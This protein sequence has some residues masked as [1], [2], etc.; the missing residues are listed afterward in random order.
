MDASLSP[1]SERP[2][3][4]ILFAWLSKSDL[5]EMFPSLSAEQQKRFRIDVGSKPPFIGA[6]Q[7]HLFLCGLAIFDEVHL[8]SNFPPWVN[9]YYVK[10]IKRKPKPVMRG[11]NCVRRNAKWIKNKVHVH[12]YP[13]ADND[14]KN[15]HNVFIAVRNCLDGAYGAL[16]KDMVQFHFFLGSGTFT[17]IIV[18]ILLGRSEYP[19]KFWHVK[20]GRAKTQKFPFDL[21]VD[22][23][24]EV[25]KRRAQGFFDSE[26]GQSPEV[27]GFE[28]IKGISFAIWKAKD[29]AAKAAESDE[30]VLLLGER[31]TGKELFAEAIHNASGRKDKPFKVMNCG[32]ISKELLESE[33]FGHEKGSFTGAVDKK[34]A[35]EAANG[36][37]LFLDEIGECSQALQVKLL[38][39]LQPSDNLK[40][41]YRVFSN[42]GGREITCDVRVI[43]A[44]NRDLGKAQE[45]GIFREDLYDRVN[46]EHTIELPPLRKRKGDALFLAQLFLNEFNENIEKKGEKGKVLSDKAKLFVEGY[47]WF[48][49]VRQLRTVIRKAASASTGSVILDTE[50]EWWANKSSTGGTGMPIGAEIES[51]KEKAEA[52]R[53]GPKTFET[54]DFWQHKLTERDVSALARSVLRVLYDHA[55]KLG[56]VDMSYEEIAKKSGAAKR[57]VQ[58]LVKELI[59]KMIITKTNARG[60]KNIYT[61]VRDQKHQ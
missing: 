21:V 46:A 17:M 35:F 28:K 44:T 9:E 26:G 27:K 12:H 43:A 33:L 41:C 48:G 3:K 7:L 54:W 57:T 40:P 61:L 6:S 59:T 4:Q 10:W 49:N 11:S 60:G 23:K 36:G 13:L 42:V 52:N 8:L 18:W 47:T 1:L 29:R 32:S 22:F 19:A 31:G 15:F 39:V 56:V 14:P 20:N 30:I 25:R 16:P 51:T 5:S 38:R 45:D 2:K 34:G 55:N 24:P 53:R 50:I 37:T 58:N